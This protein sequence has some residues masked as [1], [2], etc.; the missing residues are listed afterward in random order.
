[1]VSE[2]GDAEAPPAFGHAANGRSSRRP[3]WGSAR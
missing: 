2:L 3:P 1:V